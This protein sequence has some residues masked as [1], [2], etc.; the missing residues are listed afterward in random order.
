MTENHGVTPWFVP[1]MQYPRRRYLMQ[2][3]SL[4]QN[5]NRAAIRA[6]FPP[7]CADTHAIRRA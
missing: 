1:T 3:R 7:Q 2:T 5:G 6:W 4:I